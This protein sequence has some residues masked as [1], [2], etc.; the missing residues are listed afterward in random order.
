MRIDGRR[1]EQP[2]QTRI[3]PG[4][5]ATAEGS[6]LIEA[7]NT[8]VICSATVENRVPTFLRG[9]GRGWV[10]AEYGMLPRSTSTR[11]PRLGTQGRPSGRTF[12]IQRLIGRSLRTAVDME[13]LGERTITVDCDVMQA[14]GGTR[15]ASITGGWVAMACAV[16]Q[17]LKFN[18]ISASPLRHYVA[19]ISVGIVDGVPMLDLCYEEDSRADVDMNVVMTSAGEFV[20]LQAS[21]EGDT[22]DRAQFD[23]QLRLAEQGIEGLIAAQRDLVAL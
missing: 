16:K 5:L 13:K 4:I 19:A 22:F 1:P 20:E 17:L 12:E 3:Q 14:D 15:T 8:K 10:T 2:R 18:V 11:T 21:A 6:A 9:A 23:A 7:G